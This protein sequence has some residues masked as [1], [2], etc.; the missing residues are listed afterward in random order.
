MYRINNRIDNGT[1]GVLMLGPVNSGRKTQAE[2]LVSEYRGHHI[3]TY[4][5]V[6]TQIDDIPRSNDGLS[7]EDV[8][9]LTK[10]YLALHMP[11][12]IVVLNGWC[13]TKH[14]TDMLDKLFVKPEHLIAFSFDIPL[15]V[16]QERAGLD[17]RVGDSEISRRFRFWERNRDD[18]DHKLRA[19]GVNVVELD[20]C[21]DPEHIHNSV[22]GGVVNHLKALTGLV[23]VRAPSRHRHPHHA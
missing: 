17:G 1:V 15:T 2:K 13:R 12:G 5:L 16:A 6:C 7:D 8:F 4:Q 18:V 3:S 9:C 21:H 11:T 14:Q 22:R 19:K 20:G 23:G 10:E